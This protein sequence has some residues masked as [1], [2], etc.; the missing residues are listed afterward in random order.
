M[1]L[2]KKWNYEIL[3]SKLAKSTTQVIS[4]TALNNITSVVPLA[5]FHV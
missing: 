2:P 5:D 4:F 3:K 1:I